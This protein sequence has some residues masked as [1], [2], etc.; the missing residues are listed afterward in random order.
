M[1][2][3]LLS[4]IY[5]CFVSIGLPDA[6]L[7]SAWP[8]MYVELGA[9]VGAESIITTIIT[10]STIVS[11][12][13][14]APL[15]RRLET[16]K[17]TV[18]SVGMIA[19]AILGFAASTS[20][21]QLCLLAV[22]FG[23]GAG[24]V[25]ASLNNY[26]ALHY[27]VRH[28]SW[29]H[30]CWGIGASVS[31][32]IMGWALAGPLSWHAGYIVVGIVQAC[33]TAVLFFSLPL[34]RRAFAP[35]AADAA[36]GS[37]GEKDPGKKTPADHGLAPAA[38]RVDAPSYIDLLRLPGAL[39]AI[40]SF[41][42]YSGF[43]AVCD[44]WCSSYLVMACGI[45]EPLAADMLSFFYMGLTGGRLLSG[46]IATRVGGKN[47]IRLGQAVA[48]VGV[49][50]LVFGQAQVALSVAIALIGLGCAPICPTII[51][52]TPSRFGKAVSPSMVSLQMGCAYAGSI[53]MPMFVS[54][55]VSAGG[56]AFMPWVLVVILAFMALFGEMT[57]A[58]LSKAAPALEPE[59][60]LA[61]EPTE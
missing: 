14:T 26:V 31:P 30:C 45:E 9:S 50:L 43:E 34:W 3:L 25:D 32:E 33:M 46:I 5:V 22:P 48:G 58:K 37:D 57:N 44:L 52:L 6:L 24:S 7:G 53:L 8:D 13:A 47:L 56:A 18:I 4:M 11:T 20:L 1:A 60:E 51:F 55:L 28:M 41:G 59:S 21:W 15:L 19:V 16:G 38:S 17:L 49:L 12:L 2:S 42:C 35:A 39:S 10:A 29:L 23:L 36:A 40:L 27:E 61:P 54:F